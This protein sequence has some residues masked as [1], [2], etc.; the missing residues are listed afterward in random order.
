[1]FDLPADQKLCLALAA[2][3]LEAEDALKQHA[4][5]MTADEL[6]DAVLSV[7]GSKVQ[8]E[9]AFMARRKAELKSGK[10]PE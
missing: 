10:T 1:M 2:N 6:H 3:G 9:A 5:A 8:A 7:T 4:G